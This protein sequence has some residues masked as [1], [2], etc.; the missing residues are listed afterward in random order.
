MR[1]ESQAV[2]TFDVAGIGAGLNGLLA[3]ECL[4]R[5]GA[6]VVVLAA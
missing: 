6:R 1:A 3:A 2:R 4:A 5:A